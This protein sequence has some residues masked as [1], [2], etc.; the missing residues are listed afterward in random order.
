VPVVP[1]PSNPL[2]PRPLDIAQGDYTGDLL[3]EILEHDVNRHFFGETD[4]TTLWIANLWNRFV[5]RRQGLREK[6][7][8]RRE[9]AHGAAAPSPQALAA[10]RARA[11]QARTAPHAH[12][13]GDF[14]PGYREELFGT[15]LDETEPARYRPPHILELADICREFVS[16]IGPVCSFPFFY[17]PQSHFLFLALERQA[18]K[19]VPSPPGEPCR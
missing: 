13:A 15:A 11:A 17:S 1:D 5:T 6:H 8:E 9:V 3:N 19:P 4:T 12:V 2:A 16:W 7:C 18:A 14:F 10:A